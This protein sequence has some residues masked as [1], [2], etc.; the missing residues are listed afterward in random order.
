MRRESTDQKGRP[1]CLRQCVV[2][3]LSLLLADPVLLSQTSSA[4]LRVQPTMKKTVDAKSTEPSICYAVQVGAYER[5]AEATAMLKQLMQAFPYRMALSQVVAGGKTRWRL[6]VMA[7]SKVEALQI[8]DRLLEEQGIKAWIDSIPCAIAGAIQSQDNNP[9]A[10][11]NS[12]FGSFLRT[13]GAELPRWK[14]T[15]STIDVSSLSVSDEEGKQI[16]EWRNLS[17]KCLGFVG[18]DVVQLSSRVSL[19]NQIRLLND[20]NRLASN[21]SGLGNSLSYLV[22]AEQVRDIPRAQQLARVLL[23]MTQEIFADYQ[24]FYPHV[25]AVAA[26]IDSA[27]VKNR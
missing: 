15:I 7:T 16:E 1:G 23:D 13:F 12:E 5:R 4:A 21:V 14:A 20:L 6:R 22:T 26:S 18:N 9:D 25:L 2:L 19:S 24:K 10:M 8:T 3:L 11:D 17:L 27:V